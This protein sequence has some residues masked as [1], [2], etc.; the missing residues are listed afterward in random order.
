MS[1]DHACAPRV[2]EALHAWLRSVRLVELDGSLG[3][4]NGGGCTQCQ[5][6]FLP[7][8]RNDQNRLWTGDT[9]GP[10]G[11][12]LCPHPIIGERR[13]AVAEKDQPW[14]PL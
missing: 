8:G 14:Q 1:S 2:D 13:G 4:R 11:E 6:R 10:V 12:F 9:S 3:E 7:V 5:W